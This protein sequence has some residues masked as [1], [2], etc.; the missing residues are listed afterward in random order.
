MSA[1]A[2][3]MVHPSVYTPVFVVVSGLVSVGLLV[4]AL[5]A[6]Q[7]TRDRAMLLMAAAFTVFAAKNFL[8]GWA[9]QTGALSTPDLGIIDAVADLATILLL[10]APVLIPRNRR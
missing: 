5:R 7:R 6:Y 10:F 2:V 1:P 8:L 9:I 3:A 4:L